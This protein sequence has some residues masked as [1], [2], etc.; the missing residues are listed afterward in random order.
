MSKKK[1]EHRA[2]Y[3]LFTY[4][5]FKYGCKCQKCGCEV[6]RRNFH[7]KEDVLEVKTFSLIVKIYDYVTGCYI[8]EISRASVE[9]ILA[10]KD[11]GKSNIENLTLFCRKCN[12][13]R[14]RPLSR[15]CKGCNNQFKIEP[16]YKKFCR[17][18]KVNGIIQH[19]RIERLLSQQ[20]YKHAELFYAGGMGIS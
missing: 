19:F 9:H 14:H 17:T 15:V 8:K 4:M 18:C 10:V 3:R 2:S 16:G 5:C 1:P 6:T 20:K 7:K 12:E 13:E 11:G